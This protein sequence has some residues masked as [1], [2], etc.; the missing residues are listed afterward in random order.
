MRRVV[1]GCAALI[2]ATSASAAPSECANFVGAAVVSAD[3]DFLGNLS[4]EYDSKSIFNKYGK[5][6][7]KYQTTSIWNEQGKF[8]GKY[9]QLSPFN[10]YT[11]KSPLIIKGGK[12]IARLTKNKH[13]AGAVDPM[14]LAMI[15]FEYEP[16]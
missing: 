9:S 11:S 1:L 7:S 10:Q 15:C 12:A 5:Y 2:A 6:G 8:G 13:T 3:G 4:S 14:M 16:E